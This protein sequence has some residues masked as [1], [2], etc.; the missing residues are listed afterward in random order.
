MSYVFMLVMLIILSNFIGS[1]APYI[2]FHHQPTSERNFKKI[3]AS[4]NTSNNLVCA[5]MISQEPTS[6]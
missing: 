4:C 3:Y 2:N 1:A 6:H 5:S